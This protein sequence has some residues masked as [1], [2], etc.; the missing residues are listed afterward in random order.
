MLS[1]FFLVG[2]EWC[3]CCHLSYPGLGIGRELADFGLSQGSSAGLTEAHWCGPFA[4]D[5]AAVLYRE[6]FGKI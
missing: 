1:A 5:T 6:G 4:G 3:C 2:R